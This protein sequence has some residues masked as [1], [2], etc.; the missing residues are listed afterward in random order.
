MD[1]QGSSP[2]QHEL[3]TELLQQLQCHLACL[4]K[5]QQQLAARLHSVS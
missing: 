1:S 2:Q 5:Q 4:R 3:E